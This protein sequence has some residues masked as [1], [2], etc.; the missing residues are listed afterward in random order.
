MVDCCFVCVSIRC[1]DDG[2]FEHSQVKPVVSLLS[3]FRYTIW[4]IAFCVCGDFGKAD[5][6]KLQRCLMTYHK[7]Q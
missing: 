5:P 2:C 4:D 7:P 6:H 1:V 3:D